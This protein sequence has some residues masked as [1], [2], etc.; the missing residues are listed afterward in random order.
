M[1]RDLTLELTDLAA[2]K[3]AEQLL[4]GAAQ[5]KPHQGGTS[6]APRTHKS[7]R[8]GNNGSS[9]KQAHSIH[10]ATTTALSRRQYSGGLVEGAKA[11]ASDGGG[12][13]AGSGVAGR[14]EALGLLLKGRSSVPLA[15]LEA[16]TRLVALRLGLQVAAGAPLGPFRTGTGGEGACSGLLSVMWVMSSCGSCIRSSSLHPTRTSLLTLVSCLVVGP[17]T[18]PLGCSVLPAC[19]SCGP[20]R[21]IIMGYRHVVL[22]S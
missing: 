11:A 9:N 13:G 14:L 19:G 21:H 3:G 2:T 1:L 8:H 20:C 15:G 7:G 16:C 12:Q 4:L 6:A 18:S 22:R 17:G 5:A 10:E